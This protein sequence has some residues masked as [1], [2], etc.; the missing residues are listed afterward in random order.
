MHFYTRIREGGVSGCVCCSV[1]G[2][3]CRGIERFGLQFSVSRLRSLANSLVRFEMLRNYLPPGTS[4]SPRCRERSNAPS[5]FSL[6]CGL[7]QNRWTRDISDDEF[8]TLFEI[9]SPSTEISI[10]A[11]PLRRRADKVGRFTNRL[12]PD[13]DAVSRVQL[14]ARHLRCE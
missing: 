8:F 4:Q 12:S 6:C 2:T 1:I 14:Y 9:D 10:F 11:C 5:K 7:F 3:L 13:F